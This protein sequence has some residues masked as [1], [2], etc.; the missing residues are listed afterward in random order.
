MNIQTRLR[1]QH[2][3]AAATVLATTLAAVV[4]SVVA[5]P[6]EA[7]SSTAVATSSGVLYEGCPTH[8][9]RYQVEDD[10]ATYDWA[11]FVTAY[12]P[13]GVEVS[14]GSVWA[15]EG[16][17]PAGV[18]TGDDGLQIC[19]SELAGR[20]T[21]TAEI[22]FYGGPY[23]DHELP[24]SSFTM[25]EARSRT[26]LRASDTT[27]T[28]NQTLRFTMTSMQEYPRGYFGEDY[29]TVVLQRKTPT[30][31]KRVGRYSTDERG[32]A[33]ARF[34]WNE[35]AAVRLRAVT[36]RSSDHTASSSR[37]ITIR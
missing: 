5:Q 23:N 29:E 18:A 30:G 1:R 19:S 35:R 25:R 12:D 31:W 36:P 8:P 15:D 28:Y 34:R 13:R 16:A 27:A 7:A 4:T 11:I 32:D 9:W 37:I 24:S 3:A 33:I 14:S 26:S 20:Y 10:Q 22:H 6:A 17:P 2:T 21:L